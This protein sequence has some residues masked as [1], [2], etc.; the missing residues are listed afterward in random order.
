M[1]FKTI[2]IMFVIFLASFW[3]T[4]CDNNTLAT[5]VP[6]ESYISIPFSG[7]IMDLPHASMEMVNMVFV[8][9]TDAGSIIVGNS[10]YFPELGGTVGIWEGTIYDRQYPNLYVHATYPRT[11][12]VPYF[13]ETYD[14]II[15][16]KLVSSNLGYYVPRENPILNLDDESIT[17]SENDAILTGRAPGFYLGSSISV[18]ING[19]HSDTAIAT[20]DGVWGASLQHFG[21]DMT[22]RLEILHPDNGYMYKEF[23]LPEI[24]SSGSYIDHLSIDDFEPFDPDHS[25]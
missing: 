10:G 4:S 9:S 3:A 12:S 6:G 14:V 1:H 18:F 16:R 23:V 19:M 13:A 21:T 11:H 17:W 5:M 20:L 2:S 15:N 8:P 22:I 7:R 24:V 25:E